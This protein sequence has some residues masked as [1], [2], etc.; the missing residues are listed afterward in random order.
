MYLGCVETPHRA[1][2]RAEEFGLTRIY[3]LRQCRV[4]CWVF[5]HHSSQHIEKAGE[6]EAGAHG[7]IQYARG[8]YA[9]VT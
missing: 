8:E 3:R 2:F 4:C 6:R 5:A 7:A 1:G 9:N